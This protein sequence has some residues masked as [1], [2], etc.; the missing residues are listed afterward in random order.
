MEQVLGLVPGNG[1]MPTL[2]EGSWNAVTPDIS[3]QA[4]LRA[5]GHGRLPITNALALNLSSTTQPCPPPL[6]CCLGFGTRLGPF[7]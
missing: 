2:A 7:R 5:D 1:D 4:N 6:I 3:K